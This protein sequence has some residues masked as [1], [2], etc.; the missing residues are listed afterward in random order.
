MAT[1]TDDLWNITAAQTTAQV[2]ATLVTPPF[3]AHVVFCP[4]ADYDAKKS[5]ACV[6]LTG[7]DRRQHIAQWEQVYMSHN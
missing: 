7:T 3:I 5:S 2:C 4:D 6:F 1:V